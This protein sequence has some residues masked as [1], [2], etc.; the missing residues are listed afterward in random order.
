MCECA[1][2][3]A[4]RGVSSTNPHTRDAGRAAVVGAGTRWRYWTGDLRT[5]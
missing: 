2:P 5:L 4:I 1:E 3:Y